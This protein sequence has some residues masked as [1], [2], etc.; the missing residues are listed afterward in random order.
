M[1]ELL[2]AC[3]S[4]VDSAMYTVGI[5]GSEA[6]VYSSLSDQLD[7]LQSLEEICQIYVQVDGNYWM[8]DLKENSGFDLDRFA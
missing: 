3:H 8:D 7:V 1:V 4:S 2:N 5:D 6:F